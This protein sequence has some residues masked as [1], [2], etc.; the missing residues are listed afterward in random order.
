MHQGTT[1][2]SEVYC[3]TLKKLPR[4]IQNKRRGI[5]TSGVVLLHDNAPSRT[6]ARARALLKY[7]NCELFDHPH[8][9]PDLAPSDYHLFTYLKNW[10]VSQCLK[11]NGS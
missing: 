7:S 4:A 1:I 10:L 6:A 11:N 9:S 5:L 2:T 8:Y 3:D